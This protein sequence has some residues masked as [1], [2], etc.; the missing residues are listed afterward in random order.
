[1]KN[2]CIII[3]SIV[4]AVSRLNA[5]PPHRDTIVWAGTEFNNAILRA[6]VVTGESPA[7]NIV[8]NGTNLCF[9][10]QVKMKMTTSRSSIVEQCLYFNTTDG[11]VAYL[12]PRTAST[13]GLCDIKPNEK[14]FQFSVIGLKGNVYNYHNIEVKD[15]ITKSWVSTGNTQTHQY[16]MTSPGVTAMLHKKTEIRT[17]C[18]GR[19]RA[20]AYKFDGSPTTYYLFGKTYPPGINVASNKYIGN[21]GIGYQQTDKGLY[22]IMEMETT[23]GFDTKITDVAE[24]STCFNPAPFQIQEDEFMR[25]GTEDLQ[26]E[27]EK[28]DRDEA[29]IR[30]DDECAAQRQNIIVFR[31]AQLRIQEQNLR[32]IPQGNVYQDQRVQHAYTSM[33]DP[34]FIVQGDI[35]N[36]QLS[37]C[38]NES[39]QSKH[40]GANQYAEKI[41]CLQGQLGRL[42][43]AESQMGALDAA[44]ATQ[45][46]K[47]MA[48][49]SRLYLQLM[50]TACN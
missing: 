3:L 41:A 48:E 18:G 31:R 17:Y 44:Y 42:H 33:M 36:V 14:D 21:F 15:G 6:T 30:S 2:Y 16:G 38:T 10:R 35:L 9:D 11:Y 46:G 26:R 8:P 39:A 34:L 20:W 28:I 49:K 40:P 47:A 19:I 27:R 24:V 5:Q 13:G 29:N 1:M 32:T 4:F 22:M 43:A 45:P 12:P 50:R 7:I 25:K 23:G 37:I